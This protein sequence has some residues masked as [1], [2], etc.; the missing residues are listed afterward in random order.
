MIVSTPEKWDVLSRR[1]KQRKN[2]Q[3]VHLF[4][5]DEAHLIGGENGVRNYNR[6]ICYCCFTSHFFRCD[7]TVVIV[8]CWCT[9]CAL[10]VRFVRVL[11]RGKRVFKDSVRLIAR[12]YS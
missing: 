5:L 6:A 10:G 1:W 7:I 9:A 12:F 11:G 4:V 8:S 3:N 2:V